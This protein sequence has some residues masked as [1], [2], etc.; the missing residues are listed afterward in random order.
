MDDDETTVE[1]NPLLDR[2]RRTAE[3]RVPLTVAELN[4]VADASGGRPIAWARLV[5][6]A[7]AEKAAKKSG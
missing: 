1:R 7:A 2:E 4:L 3:L 6:L 5:L